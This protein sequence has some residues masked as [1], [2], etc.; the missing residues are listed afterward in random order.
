M[1]SLTPLPATRSP[2]APADPWST[3]RALLAILAVAVLVVAYSVATVS[4]DFQRDR[5]TAGIS[6]ENLSRLLEQSL[7]GTV[8]LIDAALIA[9]AT[10]HDRLARLGELTPETFTPVLD[11]LQTRLP[12]SFA[13]RATNTQGIIRY[14]R[15]AAGTAVD[16]SDRDYFNR[17]K[18]RDATGLDITTPIFARLSQQWTLVFSRRLS[19]PGGEFA[20]IVYANLALSQLTKLFSSVD[21][22]PQGIIVLADTDFNVLS[23]SPEPKGPEGI[24]GLKITSPPFLALRRE[25][26][27]AATYEAP[28]TADGLLRTYSYRRVEGFPLFVKVGLAEDDYLRSARAG[29]LQTILY[30]GLFL[31]AQSILALIL[32]R[33]AQRQRFHTDQLQTAL[34]R[35]E[36]AREAADA[37]NHAKSDFLAMMS[38]EIRTPIT[39][40]LGMADLLLKTRLDGEQSRYV[41]T[42]SASAQTLLVILN[43]VLDSSKVEAGKLML[44]KVP[45]NLR[46]AVQQALAL[47]QGIASAK[48]LP[49]EATLAP[50][51]PEWVTGD[52]NRVKQILH[53]MTSNAI[54]F[55]EH[56]SVRLRLSL[57][58]RCGD[59][60]VLRGEVEDTGLGIAPEQ[61]EKLFQPFSQLAPSSSRR[62][63]GTGLGLS[64]SRRL[65]GL[66]GGE[67]GVDSKPGRGSR[68]WFTLRLQEP[69]AEAL[70]RRDGGKTA[71]A[72]R[73]PLRI[74]LAEDNRIN[75]MLVSTM[76]EKLGHR[77]TIA[78]NGRQALAA[79]EG[80]DFDAVLM[81]MQMPEMDGEEATRAIRALAPPK[82]RLPVLALT[83]DA[84]VEHRERYLAAG[85]DELVPKPIDWDA[86]TAALETHTAR[87]AKPS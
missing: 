85:V 10:E 75:Q 86:L 56:G 54:K 40:V 11:R 5:S 7:R 68:F 80:G 22:G 8:R 27:E 87:T 39:G 52:P 66:M 60:V 76:L 69:A 3:G 73:R 58:E 18:P 70:P 44:E 62:Y 51:L 46:D 64:I 67:I 77:V 72:S 6:A 55:T 1:A 63:G 42:L 49:L 26:K 48:G 41:D 36:T 30:V 78:E 14:G 23:R 79:V 2:D 53:N 15:G 13:I 37:A 29:R 21:V 71:V 59:T 61:C 43:D 34:A 50:D 20:G 74:L 9:A 32:W 82:N 81:D 45:F 24:A 38:H 35:A 12:E 47:H 84:M 19:G 57:Q 17:M 16:V 83:A 4:G 28:S 33:S 31:G 25:G 65:V